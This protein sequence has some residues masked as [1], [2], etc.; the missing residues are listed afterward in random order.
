MADVI[1]LNKQRKAKKRAQDEATAQQNRA[2]FGRTKQQKLE[3][4]RKAE[5]LQKHV[6]AHKRD[7]PED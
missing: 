7:T 1:N 4:K 2:K 6:D 3:E 5:T